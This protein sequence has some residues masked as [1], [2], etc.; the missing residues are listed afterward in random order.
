MLP[1]EG[2]EGRQQ[3]LAPGPL[4]PA[5]PPE[6]AAGVAGCADLVPAYTLGHTHFTG[7]EPEKHSGV[8]VTGGCLESCLAQFQISLV[9]SVWRIIHSENASVVSS[10]LWSEDDR[11]LFRQAGK[12][13]REDI[14]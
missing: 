6:C 2:G 1:Q 7:P 14:L 11:A 3:G 4:S 9:V 12:S 5:N 8:C 10:D 13:Q